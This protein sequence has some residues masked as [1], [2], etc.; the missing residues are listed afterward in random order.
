MHNLRVE[1]RRHHAATQDGQT[2]A[3]GVELRSFGHA[4]Q[5]VLGAI[6]Q[7]DGGDVVQVG[8]PVGTCPGSARWS[9]FNLRS[10]S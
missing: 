6:L 3:L 7:D 4:E 2:G 9:A 8:G 10:R 1:Q 5:I